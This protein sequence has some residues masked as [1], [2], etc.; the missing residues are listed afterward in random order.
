MPLESVISPMSAIQEQN[1][2]LLGWLALPKGK[3]AEV[4]K[5]LKEAMMACEFDKR[6][7]RIILKGELL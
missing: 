6:N 3:K 2:N 7:D 4:L 5:R 1:N